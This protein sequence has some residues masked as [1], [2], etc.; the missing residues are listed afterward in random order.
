MSTRKSWQR[1]AGTQDN[2]IRGRA[3]Q[4]IRQR[5]L[6]RTDGLCEH[7]LEEGRTEIAIVV[8][9]KI[10]LARGGEDVD[11][12]TENL[13]SRHDDIVTAQQFGKAEPIEARGVDRSGRPSSPD[14]PWNRR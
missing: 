7:C 11:D 3:G 13:C 4:R 14:H 5:R 12:N 8:N 10:P 6:A 2:R 1:P 9:H